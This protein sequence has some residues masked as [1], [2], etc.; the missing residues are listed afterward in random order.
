VLKNKA[1]Q[2]KMV[3]DVP[4]APIPE[5]PATWTPESVSK[6]FQEQVMFLMVVGA[7]SYTIKTVLDTTSQVIVNSTSQKKHLL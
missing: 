2:V 5:R 4:G 1:F 6:V 7:V 3:Q